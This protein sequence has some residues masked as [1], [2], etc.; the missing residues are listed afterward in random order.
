MSEPPALDLER[1]ICRVA[2][3]DGTGARA[4]T[5]GTGMWPLRGF[6]VRV[7]EQ[8]R[9]YVNRCP[10]AQHPLNLRPHHFL[11]ADGALILCNSHGALF[12]KDSGYCVAGPCAGQSLRALPITVDCGY[13]LLSE[14]PALYASE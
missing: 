4:F 7:R 9:A 14:D 1:V 2:D 5:M 12:D 10:H 8:I 13:V 11:T 3:L 6:V